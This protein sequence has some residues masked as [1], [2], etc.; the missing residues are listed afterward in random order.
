VLEVR[1]VRFVDSTATVALRDLLGECRR[2]GTTL[3]LARA[4]DD[5]HPQHAP[6][7]DI[8]EDD[9]RPS[10]EAAIARG[11][12]VIASGPPVPGSPSAH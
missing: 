11:V 8:G 9:I 1:L 5:H 3:L 12:A 4:A 6:G 10:I 7:R 2:C